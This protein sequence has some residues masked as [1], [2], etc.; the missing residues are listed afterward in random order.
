MFLVFISV[1]GE[2]AVS[3]GKRVK[4]K[5][6]AIAKMDLSALADRQCNRTDHIY[7]PNKLIKAGRSSSDL[8]FSFLSTFLSTF[9]SSNKI[10]AKKKG[11]DEKFIKKIMIAIQNE[12]KSS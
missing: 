5:A 2:M 10:K 9:L 6:I 1:I 7:L 12:T 8:S 11:L 4:A 3:R